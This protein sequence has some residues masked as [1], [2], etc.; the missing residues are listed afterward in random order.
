M[1]IAVA[2]EPV[3]T[4]QTD[5]KWVFLFSELDAVEVVVKP[6][7]WDDV[8]ALLGCKGANLAEMTRLGG[9][10]PPRF[11][12]STQAC[13]AYL[14]HDRKFPPGMWEQEVAAMHKLEAATGKQ[15]GDPEN[16][17]FVSCRSG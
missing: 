8:K 3:R 10:V 9:P 12:V 13:N 1:A 17:L 2:H 14:A 5:A 16:P 7:Q 6:K 15:F 11:T 4:E